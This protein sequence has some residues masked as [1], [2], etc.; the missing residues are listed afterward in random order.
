MAFIF[1][2][3]VISPRRI[4][5]IFVRRFGRLRVAEVFSAYARYYDLIYKDKD[6]AGEASYIDDLI[7]KHRPGA[8]TVLNLGC[9]TGKHDACLEKKGY[10]VCGV[11]LSDVMLAEAKKCTIP[12]RLEF[13]RGDVRTVNLERNFD[14]V[15][16][17]FHV[18]SYQTQNDDILAA[19]RTAGR[20]LMPGGIFIFDF[21]HGPG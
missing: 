3:P 13:F 20:H 17:L 5:V 21:W 8:K 7:Q 6:Y 15:V 18:M 12:G 1:L 11:D 9:G 14:V 4:S 10:S 16:S 19:F 2:L